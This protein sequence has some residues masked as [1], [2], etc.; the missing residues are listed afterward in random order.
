[1]PR[2]LAPDEVSQSAVPAE[3]REQIR[4]GGAIAVAGRALDDRDTRA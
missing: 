1:V 4:S 2:D 3:F